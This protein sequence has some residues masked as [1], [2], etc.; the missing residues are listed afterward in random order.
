VDPLAL[1]RTLAE[2]IRRAARRKGWTMVQLAD[3]ADVSKS[4]VY[5]VVGARRAATVDFIAKISIALDAAP[6]ELLRPTKPS[7]R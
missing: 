3:F 6:Q 7:K 4:Q 1:R 5:D 2:N